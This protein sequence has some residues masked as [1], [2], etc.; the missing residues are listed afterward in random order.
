MTEAGRLFY[1]RAKEAVSSCYLLQDT[2]QSSISNDTITIGAHHIPARY[3]LPDVMALYRQSHPNARFL[4]KE[5]EDPE[6]MDFFNLQKIH[7]C[8]VTADTSSSGNKSQPFYDDALVLGFPNTPHYRQYLSK[9]MD[10]RKVLISEDFIWIQEL[11][12][13]ITDYLE[14]MGLSKSD[15]NI[16][17]EMSSLLLA[18]NAVIEGLGIS[19]LSKISLKC[20]IKSEEILIIDLEGAKSRSIQLISKEK[21]LLNDSEKDFFR[22]LTA[23]TFDFERCNH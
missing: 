22:F 5:G 3:I 1:S 11:D 6:I 16:V 15:L 19:L 23:N 18:K 12:R 17:A 7:I 8:F 10:I 2:V 9:T 13:E 4:L 14:Q 20:A 21:S